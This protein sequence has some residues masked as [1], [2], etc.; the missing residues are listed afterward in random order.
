LRWLYDSLAIARTLTQEDHIR[1]RDLAIRF[2]L[3]GSM[4]AVSLAAGE[5]FNE[6][7]ALDSAGFSVPWLWHRLSAR[8]VRRMVERVDGHTSSITEKIGSR[9][10]MC[11]M[12]GSPRKAALLAAFWA[13]EE[14]LKHWSRLRNSADPD[15][16]ART[17][18]Q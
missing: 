1:V 16:L 10:D 9:M 14:L 6:S 5:F 3:T 17:L 12:A 8:D 11:R 13:Q 2:D 4:V 18:P 7:P 15:I